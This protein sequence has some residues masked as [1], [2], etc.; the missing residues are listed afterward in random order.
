MDR[1]IRIGLDIDG[2]IRD[3]Y[4]PLLEI[5]QEENPNA[6]FPPV[7][8]WEHYEVWKN[9]KLKEGYVKS[10]WFGSHAFEIYQNSKMYEKS[11]KFSQDTEI[12]LI[13]GTPNKDTAAYTLEWLKI[14]KIL[15]DEIH[16][17]TQK[18]LVFCDYYIE[19]SPA[20]LEQL[21]NCIKDRSVY[22]SYMFP[23]TFNRPWNKKCYTYNR[24]YDTVQ[25]AI[26]MIKEKCKKVKQG[27][28]T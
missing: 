12:I 25:E 22:T 2:T 15:Y 5:L 21:W 3:I 24:A 16:F 23:I 28:K 7:P 18:H 14:N 26:E 17:T 27:T 11:L 4:T 13:S 19:D 10:I 8:L 6:D 20:Y 9:L 1:K